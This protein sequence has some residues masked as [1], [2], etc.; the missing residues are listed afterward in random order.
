MCLFLSQNSEENGEWETYFKDLPQS[1]S[2]LLVLLTTA[3]NPDGNY[4]LTSA[5]LVDNKLLCD[6][7]WKSDNRFF[8]VVSEL[9]MVLVYNCH[10]LTNYQFWYWYITPLLCW[11]PLQN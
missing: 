8:L 5:L 6:L 7:F 9:P 1:L 10:G 11:I 2:S 3:N 4:D